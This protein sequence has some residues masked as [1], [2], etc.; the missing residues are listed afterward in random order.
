MACPIVVLDISE[1]MIRYNRTAHTNFYARV[2]QALTTL[3][4]PDPTGEWLAGS[5]VLSGPAFFGK[6]VEY[7]PKVSKALTGIRRQLHTDTT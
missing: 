1:C 4:G 5:I 6:L 2:T 7:M 3:A